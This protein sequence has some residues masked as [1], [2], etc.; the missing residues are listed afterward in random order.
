MEGKGAVFVSIC[1]QILTIEYVMIW[2]MMTSSA[3]LLKLVSHE[4]QYSWS[5]PGI[6]LQTLRLNVSTTSKM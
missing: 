1:A 2:L 4:V 3:L 5:A 6:D